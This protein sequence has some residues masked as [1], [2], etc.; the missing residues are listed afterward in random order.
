MTSMST[1]PAVWA[2]ATP[3]TATPGMMMPYGKTPVPQMMQGPWQAAPAAAP[4]TVQFPAFTPATAQF[5]AAA[6]PMAAP[7]ATAF[8][9]PMPM[10]F[11][12]AQ[13]PWAG[14][15][16]RPTAAM[17]IPGV[18]T[19]LNL[20]GMAG[21]MGAAD[22]QAAFRIPGFSVAVDSPLIQGGLSW[23][24]VQAAFNLPGWQGAWTW[25][26]AQMGAAT[27]DAQSA[28]TMPGMQLQVM[29]DSDGN[30]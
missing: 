21:L 30:P 18:A 9:T 26:G 24:G 27:P 7:A 8:P 17:N 6:V 2:A 14:M 16:Q 1:N 15:A 29:Q 4:G 11:P 19:G 10:A 3:W 28:M 20:Q 25:P 5:P 22:T 12:P 23:P 13:A